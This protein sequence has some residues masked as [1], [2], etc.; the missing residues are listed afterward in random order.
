MEVFMK[1]ILAFL[2]GLSVLFFSCVLPEKFTCNINVDKQGAYSADFK[3]TLVFIPALEEI[4]EN[5][6]VSEETDSGIK[7]YLD[8]S[9]S[10]ETLIKKYE[11]RNSGRVYIEYLNNVTDGSTLDLSGSL[12]MPLTIRGSDD[13]Y[14]TITGKAAG[15]DALRKFSEYVSFGYK[16]DGVVQITSELPIVDA[17]GLK[18]GRKFLFFGPYIVKQ[19]YKTFPTEDIVLK[20]QKG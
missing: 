14:I 9:V 3:G 1:K 8:T 19:E 18:V 12:G 15:S 5:G 6:K 13:G 4:G 17:G 20:I 2:A 10:K 7:E 16:L 11:Y